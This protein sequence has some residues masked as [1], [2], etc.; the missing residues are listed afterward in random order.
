MN[1]SMNTSKYKGMSL[2]DRLT[3]SGLLDQFSKALR[4][5]NEATTLIL[6]RQVELSE[7]QARQTVRSLLIEPAVQRSIA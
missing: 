7:D 3:Q 1:T 2:T 6:L 5:R 4:E